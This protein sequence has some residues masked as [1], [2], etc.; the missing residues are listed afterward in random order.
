MFGDTPTTS[1][2]EAGDTDIP[3]E[4]RAV[5]DQ[6]AEVVTLATQPGAGGGGVSPLGERAGQG[7]PMAAPPYGVRGRGLAMPLVAAVTEFG[8]DGPAVEE[9]VLTLRAR[10]RAWGVRKL[11]ALLVRERIQPLAA[12]SPPSPR[13]CAATWP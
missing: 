11:R 1:S 6:R 4:K 12:G 5:S 7:V 13:S 9:T 3:I 2:D 8:A 10:R